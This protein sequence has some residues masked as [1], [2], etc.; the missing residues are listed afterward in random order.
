MGLQ[1]DIGV[2][3]NLKLDSKTGKAM[4]K[5]NKENY[6]LFAEKLEQFM[7]TSEMREGYFHKGRENQQKEI[8]FHDAAT[9][10]VASFN[11]KTGEFISFWK[12]NR[13]QRKEFIENN[14]VI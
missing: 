11:K 8:N 7:K 1:A 5:R 4:A 9:D 6:N 14:N 13:N 2:D 10:R 12:M 3:S